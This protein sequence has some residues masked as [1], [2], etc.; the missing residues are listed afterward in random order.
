LYSTPIPA[1]LKQTNSII[2]G[3]NIHQIKNKE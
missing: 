1:T 3:N 2:D